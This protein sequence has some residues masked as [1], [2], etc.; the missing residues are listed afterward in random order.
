LTTL[1]GYE[2][3]KY[4]SPMLVDGSP[5]TL[6]EYERVRIVF[7]GIFTLKVYYDNDEFVTEKTF[8]SDSLLKFDKQELRIPNDNDKAYSIRFRIEGRGIVRSLQYT[9]TMRDQA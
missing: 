1:E 7:K 2:P 4:V 6:K 8:I 9:Y 3:I 5:S